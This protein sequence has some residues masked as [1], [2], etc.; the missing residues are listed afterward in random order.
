MSIANYQELQAAIANWLEDPGRSMRAK[1]LITLFEAKVTR[2]LRVRQMESRSTSST[3]G[4]E[5]AL[6]LPSDFLEMRNLRIN[7]NPRR[8]LVVQSP[9]NNDEW[10]PSTTTDTPRAYK[11]VGSEII[12][13]PTPDATYTVEIDYYSFTGLSD[14]APTNWLITAYPDAYLWGSLYQ[15]GPKHERYAAWKAQCWEILEELRDADRGG[16]WNGSPLI[17][18]PDFVT[19]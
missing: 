6:A 19:P 4:G 12:F 17:S 1:D 5:A 10:Y 11:I 14:A 15:I 7:T 2:S 3:T 13:S 16:R 18:R 9:H 8:T